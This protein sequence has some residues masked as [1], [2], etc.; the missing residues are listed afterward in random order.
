MQFLILIAT[1]DEI[2]HRHPGIFG[3]HGVYS[4]AMSICSQSWTIGAFFGPI[5]SG[6][7][8]EHIGYYEMTSTIGKF[9]NKKT[10]L[11]STLGEHC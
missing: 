3:P 10:S 2:E 1:I 9:G 4:R 5:L 11:S 6:Y 8:A 7:M